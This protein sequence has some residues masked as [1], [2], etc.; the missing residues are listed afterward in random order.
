MKQKELILEID[1]LYDAIRNIH[2]SVH[3]AFGFADSLKQTLERESKPEVKV[4][5]SESRWCEK[6]KKKVDLRNCLECWYFEIPGADLPCH[7]VYSEKR[8]GVIK[9]ENNL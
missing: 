5:T 2:N 7:C 1:R 4:F 3:Q 9:S 8:D 6:D